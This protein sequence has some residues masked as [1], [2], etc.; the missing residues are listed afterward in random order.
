MGLMVLSRKVSQSILVG[1]NIRITVTRITGGQVGIGIAAP[2]ELEIDRAE[3]RQA[4][5]KEQTADER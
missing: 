1:D 3:V 4:K 5:T 2:R